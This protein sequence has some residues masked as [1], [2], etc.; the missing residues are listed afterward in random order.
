MA[1]SLNSHYLKTSNYPQEEKESAMMLIR[2]RRRKSSSERLCQG[3]SIR[4]AEDGT[5]V[6]ASWKITPNVFR[7]CARRLIFK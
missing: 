7:L 5:M 3:D 6:A 1:K 2:Q 4:H